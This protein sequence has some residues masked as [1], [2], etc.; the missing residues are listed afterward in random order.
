MKGLRGKR[1]KPSEITEDDDNVKRE[2]KE[3]VSEN[4]KVQ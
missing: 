3:I 1:I 4:R 2:C